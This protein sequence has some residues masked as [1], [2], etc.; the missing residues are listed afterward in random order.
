[1]GDKVWVYFGT[2]FCYESVVDVEALTN[3]T[4]KKGMIVTGYLNGQKL[5]Y[6]TKAAQQKREGV[7]VYFGTGFCYEGAVDVQALTNITEKNGIIVTGDLNGQKLEYITKANQKSREGVWVYFGTGVSYK[8]VVDVQALTNITE[9]NGIIVTGDLDDC[10]LEYITKNALKSR[11]GVWVYFGTGISYEGVVDVQALTNT[12]KKNGIIVTGDLNGHKLEYITK[13]ALKNRKGVWVYFGT[14]IS[15][16]GVVDVQALTNITE[17]NGIIV[18]GDLNGHKLEYITKAAQKKREGVWVYFG[19]GIGY[20][21]VVDIQALTNTT[22]KN[23]IIV[24]GD[25]NGHKLEYITKAAQKNREGVWVYFGTGIGYEGVVDVQALTNTTEKNG[26]IVTGDLN[27]RKLEYITK[28]AQQKRKGVWVYFGTGF[29]Y[30]GV[31]DIQALTNITEKKGIIVTGDLNGHKLE[32]IT[33]STQQKRKGVWV[34]FGTGIGYEGVVDIQALTNITEKNGIIVT[35]DLNGHKLEYITKAN[36]KNREGAAWVYFGTG[37][38]YEGVVDVQ[39]LTNTTEEKGIIVTG[40]LNGH[41]LEYITKSTQQKRK[42]VWVYFGTG[43]CYEDVVDIQALTNITEKNGIIVTGDLN[44]HKLEYITK[45]AQKSREREGVWVY[46]GTGISYKGVVDVQAL[47]NTTKKNGIIV[48]G[49]L[50]DCKLEYIT[51]TAQRLREG[52]WVYFGTGSCYEGV[53]DVQALTNTTE[54]N[55]IIVTGDLNDRKLEYITKAAQKKRE[56]VWVYSGTGIGYGGAVDVQALT[57]TTEK[58]GIIVTGYLNGQKLEYI[59]KDVQRLRAKNSPL[60]NPELEPISTTYSTTD[61]IEEDSYYLLDNNSNNNSMEPTSTLLD[62]EGKLLTEFEPLPDFLVD[63]L[64]SSIN[65]NESDIPQEFTFEYTFFS[66]N[67][68]RR[69]SKR[70]FNDSDNYEEGI[71]KNQISYSGF[72]D[73]SQD[74]KSNLAKKM[75]ISEKD[76]DKFDLK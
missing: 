11:E 56:G 5:E 34:Y 13:N 38:S 6:I 72:F 63:E 24:T 2:G 51:K 37:I 7:W 3:T 59:T 62:E 46:F 29:C 48:T 12:T 4:E 45:A 8:G 76:E 73:R 41:K 66:S 36:Q 16:E 10:K 17:K 50:N 9:K 21:G 19:T 47:T 43:S 52:V 49:D 54:K 74:S 61:E 32:Y 14:G 33:K 15:Y 26:I 67:P 23:G 68:E 70:K 22:E 25:L 39:A 42:G 57:N 44:G 30:E 60:A 18:T 40:D 53:V 28:A 20:E 58:N 64:K 75:K 35:G 71:T 55:G 65:Q 1:M 69:A 31:V 27:D